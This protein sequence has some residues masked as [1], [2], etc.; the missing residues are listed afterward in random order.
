VDIPTVEEDG[1]AVTEQG[2]SE[3]TPLVVSVAALILST[4]IELRR[5]QVKTV[6]QKR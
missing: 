3:A 5:P 1:A 2:I 4:G 6:G